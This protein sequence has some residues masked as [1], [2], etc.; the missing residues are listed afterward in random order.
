MVTTEQNKPFLKC[1]VAD[2]PE[3]ALVLSD[4]CWEHTPDKE[5]YSVKLI[6]AMNNGSDLTGSNLKKVVLRKCSIDKAILKRVNLSQAD[7][8]S[9]HLFDVNFQGADFIGANLSGCDLTHCDLR[10]ADLA[11]ADLRGSRLWNTDLRD[12]NLSECDLSGADLWNAKL[13]NVR[14]W[15][16]FLSGA[17]SISMESFLGSR[18]FLKNYRINETGAAAAEEAYRDIKQYFLF[19][20]RYNDASWASFKEKSMERI[21]L[22][23]NRDLRYIPSLLMNILC[24]YGEKPYRIIVS[25]AVTILAFAVFYFALN[26]IQ[27][28]IASGYLPTLM[29]YLYYSVIT[30]TTVGYGDFIPKAAPLFRMAAALESFI[31]VFLTGLF[32]FT[33]ARK[34]SAR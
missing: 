5:G 14:L 25:S 9:S 24:G 8:S 10:A 32:I 2:C 7:I 4:I 19:N 15:H 6:E 13:F 33:L 23:R 30:F 18:A 21:M 27:Y 1:S 20:G 22:R 3:Q 12:A 11:K 34:Y 29:D 17:K 28:S 31:G 26:A 16:G